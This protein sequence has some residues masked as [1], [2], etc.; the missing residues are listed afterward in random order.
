MTKKDRTAAGQES[1]GEQ[2]HF[3]VRRLARF[4]SRQI[5]PPGFEAQPSNQE[6]SCPPAEPPSL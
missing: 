6:L 3:R 1:R 4:D 2:I 5:P